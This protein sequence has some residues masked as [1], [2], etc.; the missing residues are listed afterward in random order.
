[1]TNAPRAGL[2]L[3]DGIHGICDLWE[4]KTMY[5]RYLVLFL[6]LAPLASQAP[7]SERSYQPTWESLATH[8]IPRWWDEG[9]FG[10][11]IHWGPYSVAGY[12]YQGKGYAEAITSDLYNRPE[13]YVDFMTGKF[14]AAP[15]DF[16]YKDMV[17]LFNAKNWD[18]AGWARL[19]R[20]SGARYV[21]PTGEHHDGFVLWESDLTPWTATRKGPE[22]DLIGEL[23]RAVRKEGLKFGISYHRERHPG[24]FA[25]EQV[26]HG[27]PH[28][29]IEEEIHR[30]P[31]AAFLYGPFE[32]SDAFI[33]DYVARWKEAQQK[34][35]PD[36]MWLDDIPIFRIAAGD[37]QVVKFEAAIR[38]M[39]ADY[40]NA[41][42]GWGKSVLFNNKGKT[43]NWPVNVGILE[44]D[45]M[46]TDGI[47][48]RWQNPATL[49]TSY[50]Y[51]ASEEEG[52]RYKTPTELVRL[53]C[54]V[55]SKNGNLL[56]NI[57]PRADGTIPQGMK[58]RLQALGDWLAVNGEAIYGSK[59]WITF[60]EFAGELIEEAGVIYTR[61]SQRIHEREFRFTSKPN[62]VYVIAYQPLDEPAVLRSFAG[63]E[64][65]ITGATVLGTGRQ[66]QW[67]L[68]ESGLRLSTA[69][70][71]P[72][73]HATVIRI[74][75]S[76]ASG[77]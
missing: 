57:G 31:E 1:M 49:G 45:N 66:A 23:A 69:S 22:R 58:T 44:A 3:R 26:V 65:T 27:R 56:L 17:P 67:E 34:Y 5:S 6:L 50:A 51:M 20:D 16:G 33:A 77:Q 68:T 10:I 62:A 37:P 38:E 42:E 12:R 21:I 15:P 41:S 60:G 2:I 55:V 28:A 61:H 4:S 59:P 14:G 8:P 76:P 46:N 53:L 70:D 75:T 7:A 72:F 32:Y 11:F 47:G 73:R 18:P 30:M 39:I 71:E 64:E 29:L 54:D 9:K 36:F 40:L 25:P 43:P 13:L 52:D 48:A 63:I 19:F 35:R 74:T 24:R